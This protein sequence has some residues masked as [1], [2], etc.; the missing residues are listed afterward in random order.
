MLDGNYWRRKYLRYLATQPRTT[1][2]LLGH[3]VFFGAVHHTCVATL[4]KIIVPEKHAQHV[5]NLPMTWL[6]NAICFQG[7]SGSLGQ[8]FLNKKKQIELAWADVMC[9]A[10]A[11]RPPVGRNTTL[12]S[13]LDSA[14]QPGRQQRS[15]TG[16]ALRIARQAKERTYPELL[17]AE[18]CRLVV[19]GIELG[20]RWSMVE[21]GGSPIR[22]DARSEPCPF[23]PACLAVGCHGRLRLPLVCLAF[24]CGSPRCGSQPPFPPAGKSCQR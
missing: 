17:R 3:F 23:G 9:V 18:R 4:K 19:L 12:V 24:V 10:T 20:G 11:D 7:H 1:P 21:L 22:P 15:T 5:H 16:A 14:G 13:A 2:F 8:F 6:D